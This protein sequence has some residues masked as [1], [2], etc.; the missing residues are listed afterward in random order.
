MPRFEHDSGLYAYEMIEM[1]SSELA[2]SMR[3]YYSFEAKVLE[4]AR[5]KKRSRSSSSESD[6]EDRKQNEVLARSRRDEIIARREAEGFRGRPQRGERGGRGDRAFR[7]FRGDRGFR[8]G[9]GGRGG[10]H[11]EAVAVEN[12]ECWGEPTPSTGLDWWTEPDEGINSRD[13]DFKGQFEN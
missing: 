11:E 3:D 4:I 12:S 8:G 6:H 5:S 1:P 13:Y 7:Q 2:N 9:R 10:Y